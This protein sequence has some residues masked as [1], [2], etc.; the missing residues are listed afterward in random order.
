[1][2]T[3]NS[4]KYYDLISVLYPQFE[5]SPFHNMSYLEAQAYS[6]YGLGNLHKAVL[7]ALEKLKFAET[8]NSKEIIQESH[9]LLL[10]IF[11]ASGQIDKANVQENF[12]LNYLNN[13]K[14]EALKNQLIYYQTINET[15]KRY[16][17][18]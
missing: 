15:D 7:L 13:T 16:L 12:V 14:E 9:E 17:K 18:L 5:G 11:E 3:E 2:Q 4:Q 8:F 1:E 6:Q 10:L